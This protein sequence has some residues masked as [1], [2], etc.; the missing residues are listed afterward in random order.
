MLKF[1]LRVISKRRI[2]AYFMN[3]LAVITT[4]D[5]RVLRKNRWYER[6]FRKNEDVCFFPD[7][8][9]ELSFIYLPFGLDRLETAA[10]GE[11][12]RFSD[13][14]GN[15]CLKNNI[16]DVV[17]DEDVW[18]RSYGRIKIGGVSMHD[19]SNLMR[20]F[21]FDIFSSCCKRFGN[22]GVF[23]AVCIVDKDFSYFSEQLIC[24]ICRFVKYI[25]VDT[26]EVFMFENFSSRL[27]EEY[28]L[29]LQRMSKRQSLQPPGLVIFVDGDAHQA[30]WGKSVVINLSS[31]RCFENSSRVISDFDLDFSLNTLFENRKA[32]VEIYKNI[33][34][35]SGSVMFKV[36]KTHILQSL[37]K[38]GVVDFSQIT[39]GSV[40]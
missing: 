38:L 29:V 27:Y 13:G 2:S 21:A 14:V 30:L 40:S 7:C 39:F 25:Y 31:G 10:K 16:A 15:F 4:Y 32:S 37:V 12:E 18:D 23:S 36:K 19:G 34:N 3:R 28:G 11:L 33:F 35:V 1:L 24:K 6:F 26:D 9:L 20:S 8:G 22:D 5:R 17:M